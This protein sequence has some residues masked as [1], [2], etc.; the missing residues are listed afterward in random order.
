MTPPLPCRR[1]IP[2]LIG[3]MSPILL[4]LFLVGCA[5]RVVTWD[6]SSS[7]GVSQPEVSGARVDRRLSKALRKAIGVAR[8]LL[9]REELRY[10]GRDFR[11]DCSGLVTGCYTVAGLELI[12]AEAKGSSGT[13]LIY[14]TL[15]RRNQV[16]TEGLPRP[17]DLVFF[18]DTWDSNGDGQ[19]GDQFTHVA[20]VEKVYPSGVVGILH[21]ATRQ[22]RRGRLDPHRPSLH[23]D[24]VT[25][26]IV[27]DWMR[28]K[29]YAGEDRLLSGELFFSYGRP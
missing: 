10:R 23:Q 9:G 2:S 29:R 11:D 14:D 5:P 15:K 24:P 1:R 28:R 12:D 13:A 16:F 26:E 18:H 19:R 7:P 6:P 22:V 8:K 27:N 25:K 4:T 17:G 21:F 3:R 20:L